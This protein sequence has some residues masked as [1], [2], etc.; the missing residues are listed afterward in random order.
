MPSSTLDSYIKSSLLNQSS[1]PSSTLDT[2]YT[3]ISPV[4]TV[5]VAH[6][7]TTM[8][9]TLGLSDPASAAEIAQFCSCAPASVHNR[10]K[11]NVQGH[12]LVPFYKL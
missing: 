2:E 9:L 5:L 8:I 10:A 12:T 7:L 4:L 6:T 3:A 1:M 11:E